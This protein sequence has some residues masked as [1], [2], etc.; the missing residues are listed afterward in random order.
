MKWGYS[1]AI[2]VTAIGDTVNT[3]SRLEAKTKDFGAQLIFS[4]H[5]A[6]LGGLD[7]S[8]LRHEEIE[9]RGRKEAMQIIV[10]E[11]AKDLMEMTDAKVTP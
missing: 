1:H 10:M 4:E 3:S 6:E 9:V 7:S 11:D 2:S 5:V 8:S